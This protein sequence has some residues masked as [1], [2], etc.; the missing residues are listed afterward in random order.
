[1]GHQHH[2]VHVLISRQAGWEFAYYSIGFT[3]HSRPFTQN[4]TPVDIQ[5]AECLKFYRALR[6]VSDYSYQMNRYRTIPGLGPPKAS[7]STVC[8]KCLK[9][10]MFALSHTVPEPH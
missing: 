2:Q 6:H 7:A 5:G 8:Q 4:C 9:K 1:M 3:R 10:D